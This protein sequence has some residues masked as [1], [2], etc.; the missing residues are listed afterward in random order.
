MI[1]I[2]SADNKL[3]K[4]AASL[5]KKKFRDELGLYLIEGP[6]PIK[7]ALRQHIRLRFIFIRAGL[8]PEDLDLPGDLS[9]RHGPAV[10]ELTGDVF[11]RLEQ[12]ENSQGVIAVAA[13]PENSAEGFFRPGGNYLVLDRIQDPGNAGTLLRTAEAM[14]FEG[15]IAIKG[16]VDLYS[17]KVVRSA[18]GS[19]FRMRTFSCESAEECLKL[20]SDNGKKVYAAFAGA[21]QALYD[22]DLKENTAIVIGNEGSGVGPAFAEKAAPLSIP[23]AGNTESLNAALAGA[24]LM[25]ESLRQRAK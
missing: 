2:S 17:P 10:Y 22:A 24:I 8:E 14:G 16:T 3:I 12:T 4:Q 23:M 21:K 9:D 11:S 5:E 6:K 19:L 7:E 13:K 18:A 15:V 1:T 25:Y 20:L